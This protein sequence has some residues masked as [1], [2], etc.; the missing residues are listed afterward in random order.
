MITTTS[1]IFADMIQTTDGWLKDLREQLGWTSE[2]GAFLALRST[3]HA[4]RDRLSVEEAVRLG[5]EL[6]L[7]I[8]ALYYGQWRPLAAARPPADFL[9]E[10]EHG[11]RNELG[12]DSEQVAG[13]VF[14][15]LS[16]RLTPAGLEGLKRALSPKLRGLWP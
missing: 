16:R 2:R 11:C 3:L 5:D 9:I 15:V 13:A 4:L 10:I 6:P 1:D 12:P 8:G 14:S 7:L